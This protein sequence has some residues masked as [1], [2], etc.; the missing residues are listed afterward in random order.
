MFWKRQFFTRKQPEM[1]PI[2]PQHMKMAVTQGHTKSWGENKACLDRAFHGLHFWSPDILLHCREIFEKK[3]D[4]STENLTPTE[5]QNRNCLAG[6]WGVRRRSR[7]ERGQRRKTGIRS[8]AIEKKFWVR[9][10]DDNLPFSLPTQT[11]GGGV[12]PLCPGSKLCFYSKEIGRR[13]GRI[14]GLEQVWKEWN[15]KEQNK[16]YHLWG[17]RGNPLGHPNRIC[18]HITSPLED[19]RYTVLSNAFLGSRA[20]QRRT[21]YGV[22]F[23]TVRSTAG[24][25][26][27]NG[28]FDPRQIG[29]LAQLLNSQ[30]C[31]EALVRVFLLGGIAI[32]R[33]TLL[34]KVFTQQPPL[35]EY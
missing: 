6:V 25:W 33:S 12:G 26:K 23:T 27:K 11:G 5:R 8:L 17:E 34:K 4:F 18:S 20:L 3:I 21:W 16:K 9:G 31:L 30:V 32:T 7:T 15:R 1:A 22:V 10:H 14:Y 35:F 2:C 29:I 19:Q 28:V 24:G 13:A